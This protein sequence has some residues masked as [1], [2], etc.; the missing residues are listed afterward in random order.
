M[1]LLSWVTNKYKKLLFR[2]YLHFF[3]FFF[4][5]IIQMSGTVPRADA[6][7][8][9]SLDC[10]LSVDWLPQSSSGANL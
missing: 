5:I 9:E 1:N 7:A 2:T 4:H 3:H 10:N 6:G 8:V